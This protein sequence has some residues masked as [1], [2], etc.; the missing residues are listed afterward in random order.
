MIKKY[1]ILIFIAS[2]VLAFF[3]MQVFAGS[4]VLSQSFSIGPLAIHYYGII[5]ALAV[6]CA[7][8]WAMKRSKNYQL[9]PKQAE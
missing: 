7:F 6:A 5:M 4:W 9:D 3:L 2:A 1:A 8:W